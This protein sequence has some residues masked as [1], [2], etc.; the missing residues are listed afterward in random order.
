MPAWMAIISRAL[1]S[2]RGV[3]LLRQ[4]V[5]EGHSLGAVWRD[6]TLV[7]LAV[8]SIAYLVI[9]WL[10]LLRCEQIAKR[11]GSLGRY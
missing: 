8:Q 5:L 1:P 9:G 11:R 10:V 7:W 6:R 2:T 4:V 3:I